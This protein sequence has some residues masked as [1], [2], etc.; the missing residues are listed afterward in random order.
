[1]GP[2]KLEFTEDGEAVVACGHCRNQVP[3]ATW[4][5]HLWDRVVHSR[6]VPLQADFKKKF[7]QYKGVCE[8]LGSEN[9]AVV[10]KAEATLA[11]MPEGVGN[12]A[13]HTS[14]QRRAWCRRC[15]DANHKSRSRIHVWRGRRALGRRPSGGE[16]CKLLQWC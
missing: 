11:V 13:L 3:V 6:A 9:A 15:H 4:S 5:Q 14:C 1:M 7:A 8:R 2:G 12:K 16:R 10:A